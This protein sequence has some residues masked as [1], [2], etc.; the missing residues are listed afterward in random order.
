MH[1]QSYQFDL[2]V[3]Q[4]EYMPLIDA[5]TITEGIWGL[6]DEW[7]I[8]IGFD[9]ALFGN[10]YDS[11]IVRPGIGGIALTLPE[12]GTYTY[13]R[14]GL[15]DHWMSDFA[16]F[17]AV[18]S[19]LSIIRY[20]TDETPTGRIFKIEFINCWLYNL[21]NLGS[22]I[23]GQIWLYESTPVVRCIYGE[24]SGLDANAY[25]YVLGPMVTIW[26][27]N[28]D[29]QIGTV[30]YLT[31]S[32]ATPQ[33]LLGNYQA[34]Y[35][36]P[37]TE[38]PATGTAY[39]FGQLFVI[40]VPEFKLQALRVW[41]NPARDYLTLDSPYPGPLTIEIYNSSGQ[42]LMSQSALSSDVQLDVSHLDQGMYHV[43]YLYDRKSTTGAAHFIIAR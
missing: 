37:L 26:Q 8:P 14:I 30:H 5:D 13:H 17:E 33:V 20:R 3:A 9:F 4:G 16:N 21:D 27:N 43:R 22:Y 31:G 41:P 1:A 38:A 19:S 11:V 23:N 12:G 7:Q 36:A 39:S 35:E 28:T 6:S 34:A 40:G 2:A 15:T 25:T 10:F 18:D 32:P 42:M 24:T 29:T